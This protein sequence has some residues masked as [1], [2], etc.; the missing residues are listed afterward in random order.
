[1]KFIHN[2]EFVKIDFIWKELT[3]GFMLIEHFFVSFGKYIKNFLCFGS[4]FLISFIYIY[5]I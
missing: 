5:Y 1:M 4:F 2:I 3:V